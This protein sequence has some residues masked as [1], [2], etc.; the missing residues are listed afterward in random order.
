ML[1]EDPFNVEAQQKIEEL[2]RQEQVMENLQSAL[3][4]HPEGTS[5]TFLLTP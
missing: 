5:F 4:H 2:I 1:N 3:E